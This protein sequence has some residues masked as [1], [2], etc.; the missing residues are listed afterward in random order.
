M[1]QVWPRAKLKHCAERVVINFNCVKLLNHTTIV[2]LF[3]NLIFPECMFNVRIFN[4]FTP[5]IIKMMDFTSYFPTVL[6]VKRFVHFW[7]ASLAKDWEEQ[8]LS[9]EN[10]V[11]FLRINPII[12]GAFFVPYSLEFRHVNYAL[13]LK[14]G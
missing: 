2:E 5:I 1:V 6:E 4:I 8:I 13:F 12:F 7:I 10:W 9:I 3:M 14:L 11:S